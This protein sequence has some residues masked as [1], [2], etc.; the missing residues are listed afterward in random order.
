MK[1]DIE[2]GPIIVTDAYLMEDVDLN[3]INPMAEFPV[4]ETSETASSANDAQIKEI[5]TIESY[6]ALSFSW[7]IGIVLLSPLLGRLMLTK[8]GLDEETREDE[9]KAAAIGGVLVSAVSV[10]FTLAVS[11]LL[12]QNTIA[13]PM[14]KEGTSF[15]ILYHSMMTTGTVTLGAA[16]LSENIDDI[17]TTTALGS[18]VIASASAGAHR[19]LS[20]FCPFNSNSETPNYRKPLLDFA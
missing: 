13:R 11:Y 6:T 14:F 10:V 7:W 15:A 20:I 8:V 5:L 17:A 18:V 1:S 16:I 3:V 4:E 19:L 9:I 2:S 12:K